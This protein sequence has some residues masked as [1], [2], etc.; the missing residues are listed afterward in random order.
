MSTR[1]MEAEI[2]YLQ[3]LVEG[4]I[5]AIQALRGKINNLKV[6]DQA[7]T[8]LK[9]GPIE[10]EYREMLKKEINSIPE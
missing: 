7:L 10:L 2:A 6:L 5:E 8:L 4:H 3:S 9:Y 1:S